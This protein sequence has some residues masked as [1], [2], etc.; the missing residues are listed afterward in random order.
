MRA[1]SPRSWCRPV[2]WAS[3]AALL[4]AGACRAATLEVSVVDDK[5]APVAR[6]AVHATAT[7]DPRASA[8]PGGAVMDQRDKR[9]DPHLLVVER[10]AAV[11]FPNN[12]DV[13]H[14]VYSFSPA[15]PFE[16]G[17]YKGNVYP[18]VLFDTP[19]VVVVGCNIHDSMLGY[20]V[21]VD[22]P[23][24]G[25]TDERG[26]ARIESLP[27]GE[28]VVKAWTERARPANLPAPR[29]VVVAAQGA[30]ATLAIGGRLAPDLERRESSLSWERY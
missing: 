6:V 27:A 28:Y 23:Y 18:P 21:V 1:D 4:V 13:S 12:D 26:I 16:L 14:H 25:V 9:F 20:I 29:V 7:R 11:R 19:G 5:G 22:T 17:L 24:F 30:T 3:F 15:K 2:E 10:G 8:L